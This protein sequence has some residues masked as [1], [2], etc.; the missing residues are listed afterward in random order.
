M[1][2]GHDDMINIRPVVT[3]GYF[4]ADQCPQQ[5]I[6]VIG[7]LTP[8][9][10]FNFHTNSGFKMF[11]SQTPEEAEEDVGEEDEEEVEGED[12]VDRM[13]HFQISKYHEY[14]RLEF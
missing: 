11:S 8:N 10:S 9:M 1:L 3:A 2:A 5:Q 12:D 7:F 13:I 4:A 6:R 14:N